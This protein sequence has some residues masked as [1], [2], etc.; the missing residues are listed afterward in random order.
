MSF[1]VKIIQFRNVSII[2]R[3]PELSGRNLFLESKRRKEFL[4]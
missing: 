2:S 3:N 4:M 1:N